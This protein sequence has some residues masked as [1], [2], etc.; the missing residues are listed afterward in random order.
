M[1]PHATSYPEVTEKSDLNVSL[2]FPQPGKELG[3]RF[4]SKHEGTNILRYAWIDLG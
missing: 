4:M 3:N 1:M 2:I